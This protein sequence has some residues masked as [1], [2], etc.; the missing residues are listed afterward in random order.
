M[1]GSTASAP[2]P[3]KRR[4]NDDGTPRKKRKAGEWSDDVLDDEAGLNRAFASMDS[5]LLADYLSQKTTRFGADLSPVELAD[6]YISGEK[7]LPSAGCSRPGLLGGTWK[8][9]TWMHA[10]AN[11]VTDTSAFEKDRTL[12]N[13]PEFLEA[14]SEQPQ[15]LGK[16]PKANGSPHTLVVAGAGLRA[17]DLVRCVS[18]P[19]G[20]E[21]DMDIASHKTGRAA[22]DDAG[23]GCQ[24]VPGQ[25][26][27]SGEARKC[28]RV[29]LAV[30]RGQFVADSRGQF[31]KH[32]KLEEAVAF[33]KAKRTGIAVGT[34]ARLMDLLDNG[35]FPSPLM[36]VC[37]Q[38]DADSRGRRAL[39]RQPA[40]PDCGCIP[41]RP[42]AARRFGHE[43]HDDAACEA[44][45]QEGVQGAV[46]GRR[47]ASC[48]AILLIT[49]HLLSA[50]ESRSCW[51]ETP[52]PGATP[53]TPSDFEAH[54]EV[55]SCG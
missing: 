19:D 49:S 35:N 44:A 23:Q 24:E 33:L 8:R 25:R 52:T 45:H 28:S 21:P 48:P 6:L 9:L 11:A 34:P 13:L 12:E 2:R 22:A 39:R 17:A 16:A 29:A 38:S 41:Y 4:Q 15:Q 30:R 1:A 3:K 46:H 27:R 20:D 31:A 7:L 37:L 10:K 26:Q 47:K 51:Y 55:L 36:S 42:E 5:Q 43:G 32:I 18:V 54:G 53:T 50:W 14:F 40:A